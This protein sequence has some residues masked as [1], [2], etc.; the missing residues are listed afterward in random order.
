MFSVNARHCFPWLSGRFPA[1]GY[2]RGGRSP[3]EVV[4]GHVKVLQREQEVVK[5]LT[6]DFDQLVVV[7]DQVLQIDQARQVPGA[8]R[9]QSIT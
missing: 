6:G 3:P 5:G 9:C 1:V 8:D 2:W 4:V 7:D